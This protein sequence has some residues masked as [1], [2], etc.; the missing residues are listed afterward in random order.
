MIY[1]YPDGRDWSN[2]KAYC[3]QNY[4]SCSVSSKSFDTGIKNSQNNQASYYIYINDWVKNPVSN[5]RP[6]Q[7]VSEVWSVDLDPRMY[8]ESVN[9]YTRRNITPWQ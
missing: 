7:Y 3:S 4:T 5:Y 2:N 9:L 6:T 8:Y 1:Y